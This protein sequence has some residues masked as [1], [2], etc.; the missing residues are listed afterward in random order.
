MRIHLGSLLAGGLLV[1]S[2]FALAQS[3]SWLSRAN[4]G[5]APQTSNQIVTSDDSAP[6]RIH[7]WTFNGRE[8]VGVTQ[9]I[10]QGDG[11]VV[12]RELKLIAAPRVR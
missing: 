9:H 12:S 2:G 7:A 4:A 6:G 8:I 1:A 11:V 3:S 10:D 5:T